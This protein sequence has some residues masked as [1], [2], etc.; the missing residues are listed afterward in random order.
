MA[1]PAP[2]TLACA[3]RV[4]R[5]SYDW[6]VPRLLVLC[7][8][9]RKPAPQAVFEDPRL[10]IVSHFYF[11]YDG[12]G[13][14]GRRRERASGA[15][16]RDGPCEGARGPAPDV[17][18]CGETLRFLCIEHIELA[19]PARMPCFRVRNIVILSPSGCR[20]SRERRERCE[21]RCGPRSSSRVPARLDTSGA[22]R[23]PV[24]LSS[25]QPDSLPVL[26]SSFVLSLTNATKRRLG[27]PVRCTQR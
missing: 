7:V 12:I 22:T 27:P 1:G 3:S 20:G 9:S 15:G 26:L 19:T 8:G 18:A 5:W 23:L 6:S 10:L 16:L 24:S 17:S 13:H 11:Y 21:R 25:A 2:L 4:A 14:A